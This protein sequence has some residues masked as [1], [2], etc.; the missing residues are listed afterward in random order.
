MPRHAKQVTRRVLALGSK[1]EPRLRANVDGAI[2]A[3]VSRANRQSLY[4]AL[5]RKDFEGALRAVP[6]ESVGDTQLT[7]SMK[8]D[9]I[10]AYVQASNIGADA[11]SS[12]LPYAVVSNAARDW[13]AKYG[14]NR[15]T[16][17]NRQSILG[18]RRALLVASDKGLNLQQTAQHILPLV[19]LREVQVDTV[20][21]YREALTAQ[22]L[23]EEAINRR[24]TKRALELRKDRTRVIARTESMFAIHGGLRD[25]WAEL[26]NRGVLEAEDEVQWYTS[27]DE[28]TC[29]IC[30]PMDLQTRGLNDEM[31]V[32]SDGDTLVDWEGNSVADP[33]A[34]PNCRCT[35]E[36]LLK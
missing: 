30:K 6:W 10:R 22:E 28:V 3:T 16:E 34:H 5:K 24:V 19:G 25:S 29:D 9:T 8:R 13:F 23:T 31:W 21:A 36:L 35:T 1:T 27:E 32:N 2:R 17:M 14:A 26:Q 33:P 11:V 15:V 20:A 18:L 7:R 12:R 4:D